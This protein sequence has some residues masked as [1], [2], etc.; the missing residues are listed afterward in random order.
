M[1]IAIPV[2]DNHV[3]TVFDAADELLMFK[4]DTGTMQAPLRISFNKDSNIAKVALLKDQGI[5]ILICGALSGFMQRMIESAGIQVLPFV[6]GPVDEVIRAFACG[7]LLEQRFLLPG[8]RSRAGM[9]RR[10]RRHSGME[11]RRYAKQ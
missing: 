8:C 3:A 7:D 4:G 1:K 11:N 6:R 10:R 5:D 2:R 9:I